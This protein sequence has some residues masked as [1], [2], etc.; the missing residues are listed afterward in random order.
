LLCDKALEIHFVT[1]YPDE[2][3]LGFV[4]FP[5]AIPLN[6]IT[7]YPISFPVWRILKKA[8]LPRKNTEKHGK[9]FR[10][11]CVIPWLLIHL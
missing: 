5:L 11:F 10:A 9:I 8:I 2:W 7:I 6:I 1:F 3:V 4:R